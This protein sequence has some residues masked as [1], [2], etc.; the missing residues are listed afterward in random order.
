MAD[1]IV[2]LEGHRDEDGEVQDGTGAHGSA[3]PT[4][5]GSVSHRHVDR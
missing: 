1:E 5:S 2:V 3:P 4:A